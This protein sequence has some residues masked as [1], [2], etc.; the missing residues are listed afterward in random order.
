[1]WEAIKRQRDSLSGRDVLIEP[2]ITGLSVTG[3]DKLDMTMARGE[4]A[5]RAAGDRLAGLSVSD[6]QWAL[7]LRERAARSHP[8]PIR[9]DRITVANTSTLPQ[10]TV[11]PLITTRPGDIL[12]GPA[13][14]RQVANIYALDSFDRVQYTIS[15]DPVDRLLT[16]EAKGARGSQRYGQ[17]GLLLG[18]DFGRNA[19]FALA[20]GFTDRD[21]L[22]TG[23]EWRGFA[24][25]GSDVL[26]DVNLYKPLGRLFVEPTAFYRRYS[27]LLIQNGTTVATNQLQVISAG[28]GIDGGMVFGNWG[29]LRAGV[30][31]GGVNP[32]DGSNL[33]IAKDSGWNTDADWRIGFTFDTLDSPTFPTRGGFGQIRYIDHISLA[34]SEFTR[35]ELLIQGSLPLT[36]GK[37]T[38]VLSGRLG[39]TS[40]SIDNFVGSYPL[41]GFLNLSGLPRNGLLGQQ[42]LLLR[43][44]GFRRLGGPSPIFDLPVYVG[45]SIEAGNVWDNKDQIS[46]GSLRTSASVFVASDTPIGPLWLAYG[47]SGGNGTIYLVLGRVF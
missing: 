19:D 23:A 18:S 29:E 13:L 2:D 10:Q 6:A 39:V 42:V 14:Q 21:F 16:F 5:A 41:G 17:F 4:A 26:F 8:T 25:V 36:R 34:G 24:R 15:G 35:N 43:A 38:L 27:S 22:G 44:A 28:T 37:N 11:D 20:F 7:Y 40:G 30:R 45:A 1:G 9:I 47:R 33:V 12:S 32:A 46:L 31:I 3:F